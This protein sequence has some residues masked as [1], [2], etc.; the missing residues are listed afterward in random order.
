[1]ITSSCSI[2]A[3]FDQLLD[4]GHRHDAPLL[5]HCT[6]G[7]ARMR[8]GAKGKRLVTPADKLTEGEAM[9]VVA[10]QGDECLNQSLRRHMRDRKSC[11]DVTR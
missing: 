7:H 1:M 2:S 11:K 8:P 5:L 4:I 9:L 3:S 6:T 10:A